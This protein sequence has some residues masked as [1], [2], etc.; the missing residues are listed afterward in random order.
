MGY[1]Y[2]LQIK[3]VEGVMMF[4]FLFIV[5]PMVTVGFLLFVNLLEEVLKK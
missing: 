5:I 1:C 2:Q 3:S 4:F